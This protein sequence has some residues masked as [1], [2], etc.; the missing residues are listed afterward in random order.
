MNLFKIWTSAENNSLKR[1]RW[2]VYNKLVP[3]LMIFNIFCQWTE[4]LQRL[5]GKTLSMESWRIGFLGQT[6]HGKSMK[7]ILIKIRHSKTRQF[8]LR[9]TYQCIIVQ[10]IHFTDKC[11][12][13]PKIRMWYD[14]AGNRIWDSNYCFCCWGSVCN[15]RKCEIATNVD[16]IYYSWISYSPT[17]VQ[18]E[19]I[20]LLALCISH[21]IIELYSCCI[22]S[23]MGLLLPGCY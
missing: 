9:F 11:M 21:E 22:Q 15:R 13:W 19:N 12:K 23:W 6:G 4:K 14:Y 7:I 18:Q 10:T 17:G 8:H 1:Q 3:N 5:K 2:Y 16:K 20:Y